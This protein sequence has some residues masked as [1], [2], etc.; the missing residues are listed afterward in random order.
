MLGPPDRR[1]LWRASCAVGVKSKP[2]E[3]SSTMASETHVF[4]AEIQQ[5]LNLMIHSLYSHKDIF[6]RELIS[7]ASDAIDR[8]RFAALTESSLAASG[9]MQIILE[10]DP[11][12]RTLAVRD[13]GIG[14]TRAEVLQNL[15]TIARSGT[16]EFL[17][18]MR[19]AKS[20][21]AAPDLIGQFGVGFYSSFMVA[22]E[23]EV[24]TRRAGESGATR[25]VSRGDG[26]FTI[27]DA[28]RDTPGTTVLLRLKDED[29][30]DGLRD[31]TEEWVLRDIVKRYSDF[32]AHPIR[33]HAPTDESRKD[34]PSSA[35]ETLNSMKALWS[36]PESE[37]EE[38]EYNEFYKHVSHDWTDPLA[39]V[40]AQLE[41]KYEARAL[42]F[43][44][45]KA[46]FDLH[47]REMAKRGIQLYAKRVFIMDQCRDLMPDH[48]RFV[49]GVVDAEDLS[50][51]VSREMLQQDRQIKAIR[52]FLEKKVLDLLARLKREESEK[53]R[54][55]W[56]EFGPAFKE[57]LLG[58]AP[59]K[60]KEKLLSLMLVASTH[61]PSDPTSLDEYIE[62]MKEGQEAIYYALGTSRRAAEQS[63]HLEAFREKGY[64]VLLLSDQVDEV[65]LQ[66]T[67]E[68]KGKK[69]QSVGR[70]EVELGTPDERKKTEEALEDK[71]REYKDLLNCIRVHMQ[72]D[73][74]EVRLSARLTSSPVCLVSEPGG[75]SFQMEE[76]LRQMGQEVPKT[77]RI[78]ELN[79]GHPLIERLQG[80][81]QRDPGAAELRDAAQ[82]LYG[83]ALLAEGARLPDPAAFS[84]LLGDLLLRG[85]PVA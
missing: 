29:A 36:R 64:E 33:L 38:A 1:G 65:W 27:G 78:L 62:R 31:Y 19:E 26:Q 55:F 49:K 58:F 2:R 42:L 13:D 3:E 10:T 20:D 84:R 51:N 46:P 70:G 11:K 25:W 61:H 82:L 71:Q 40:L 73:L 60:D 43:I 79:P 52:N 37:V 41:G 66:S 53:Y 34:D 72:E 80:V 6:L 57:G 23:V 67:S 14:M 75:L 32:V 18:Q 5:L 28:E 21:T 30:E 77:K 12:A 44:P 74:K 50:L 59:E 8:R 4:Q 16:K 69:L 9:D 54:T 81:F 15:G 47:H 39:R 24:I 85:L 76:T 48:L 7:N 56:S 83:Q 45:S 63:P 35:P 68:Y 17:R 22:N